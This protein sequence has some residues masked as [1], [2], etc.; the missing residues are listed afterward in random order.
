M[1]KVAWKPVLATAWNGFCAGSCCDATMA[2]VALVHSG[3]THCFVSEALVTRFELPV[4]PGVGMD[5]TLADRS[6]VL[7]LQTCLVPL[8]VCS[9][10]CQVLHYIVECRV[11]PQLNHDIVLGVD[12]LQATNPII[13]W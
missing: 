12:W 13:D 11:L 3:A 2:A 10:C 9:A 4:K 1:S 8:V 7:A 6:Q 5:V